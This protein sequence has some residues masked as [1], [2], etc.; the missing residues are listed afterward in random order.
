MQ[1]I[2]ELTFRAAVKEWWQGPLSSTPHSLY[3]SLQFGTELSWHTALIGQV[4]E[5]KTKMQNIQGGNGFCLDAPIAS[6]LQKSR[7]RENKQDCDEIRIFRLFVWS[8]VSDPDI[9]V[10]MKQTKSK[11][12]VFY[13]HSFSSSCQ[14]ENI[15]KIFR[16]CSPQQGPLTAQWVLIISV[17][18]GKSVLWHLCHEGNPGQ[19]NNKSLN[20]HLTDIDSKWS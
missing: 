4:C 11:F 16:K 20:L 10:D 1:L 12:A 7:R 5:W 9:N 14:S 2:L 18:T 19:Q 8:T 17:I 6:L 3:F 15:C 13:W